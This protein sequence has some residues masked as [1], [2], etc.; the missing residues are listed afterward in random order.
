MATAQ[1]MLIPSHVTQISNTAYSQLPSSRSSTHSQPHT[2]TICI[3]FIRVWYQG[4]PAQRLGHFLLLPYVPW[5]PRSHLLCFQLISVFLSIIANTI[6]T[7]VEAK[8]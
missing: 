3:S 4:L 5:V 7:M 6:S 8:T 2:C 1:Q